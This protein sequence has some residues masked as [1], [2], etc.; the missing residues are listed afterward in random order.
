MKFKKSKFRRFILALSIT[1][2]LL[3]S[4][5]NQKQTDKRIYGKWLETKVIVDCSDSKAAADLQLVAATY[6]ENKVVYEFHSSNEFST[7][8]GFINSSGSFK[9]VGDSLFWNDNGPNTTKD[10]IEFISDTKL[11]LKTKINP[12]NDCIFT[13]VLEKKN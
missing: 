10:N 13:S 6:R 3:N 8:G 11:I 2:G 4:C 1:G 9:I 7:S 12:G 5:N